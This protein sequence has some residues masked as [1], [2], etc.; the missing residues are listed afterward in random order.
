M[1]PSPPPPRRR[2]IDDRAPRRADA[3][4]LLAAGLTAGLTAGALGVGCAA[5]PPTLLLPHD[6]ARTGVFGEDGAFGAL[7][8]EHT[9]RVRGDRGLDA[10]IVA[11]TV[12]DV[13]VA[14]GPFAPVLLVQGGAVSVERYHWLAQHI[15]SRGFVV[16]APHHALDLAFFS[17]GDGLDALRA[18]SRLSD[19][20]DSALAGRVARAPA[21]A[22]GHS[23]GGVV[24]SNAFA[25]DTGGV[26]HL[27]LLAAVPNP[28]VDVGRTDGRVLSVAGGNDGLI[29]VDEVVEGAAE[30]AATTT[31]AVVEGMTHFQLT[32]E[33][34]DENLRREGTRADVDTD[35]AR[36]RALT[37]VDA[38]LADLEGD[39]LAAAV[40]DDP[41]RW[42]E[43]VVLP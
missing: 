11:P 10:D 24:A 31:V 5:P 40:L 23:L 6:D 9:F 35:V 16:V 38:M 13:D 17:Q 26:T 41:A 32:D 28:G 2:P 20:D 19:D 15:A 33:P 36:R 1:R 29:P 18:L 12:D 21:L 7:L 27:V 34:T 42:P 3:R 30:F 37:L 25:E 4:A 8:V 39:V 14:D 22:I 43:G